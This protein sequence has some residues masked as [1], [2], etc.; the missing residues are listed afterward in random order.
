MYTEDE[1]LPISALQHLSFCPRQCALIHIEG[2]WADNALTAQGNVLHEKTHQ[3]ETEARPG[4]RIARSLRLHSFRLGLVGQADVVEFH[5]CNADSPGEY[6]VEL[7]GR[8]GGW[9]PFPVEYKRGRPKHGACDEVQLCAQALCLE[10][11]LGVYIADGALFYGQPRRRLAV[12]FDLALRAA[13]AELADKFH[14]LIEGGVTPA[15]IYEKKCQSCSLL[16]ICL[17]NKT[18]GQVDA[19]RYLETALREML[20]SKMEM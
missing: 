1:L 2:Q 17:P 14:F 15:G 3:E 6:T 20:D 7:P 12:S 11:M 19:S 13:T 4:I 18:G 16:E 10:E 5:A 9:R 8:S